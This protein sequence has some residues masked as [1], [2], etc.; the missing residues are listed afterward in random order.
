MR[1]WPIVGR[2]KKT[3]ETAER[4]GTR[5]SS[6]SGE[7]DKERKHDLESRLRNIDLIWEAKAVSL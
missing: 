7:A 2:Y 3:C 5:F 1:G 4:V 6:P